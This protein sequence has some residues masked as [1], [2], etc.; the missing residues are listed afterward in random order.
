M[1]TGILVLAVAGWWLLGDPR[2][3]V[4]GVAGPVFSAVV[5]WTLL[6]TVVTGFAFAG[7]PFTRMAQPLGGLLTVALN[8]TV[9][10]AVTLLLTQVVGSWD[11]AV[12]RRSSWAWDGRFAPF[13]VVMVVAVVA[14]LARS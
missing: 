11:P 6:S 4:L 8:L 1:V 13:I 5:L 3:D 9:G 7:G 10:V 2:W 12:E 14:G